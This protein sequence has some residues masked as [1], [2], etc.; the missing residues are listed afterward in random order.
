MEQHCNQLPDENQ[1]KGQDKE[2][3]NWF[4]VKILVPKWPLHPDRVL[5][6]CQQENQQYKLSICHE[7]VKHGHVSQ[8]TKSLSDLLLFFLISIQR[9]QIFLNQFIPKQGFFFR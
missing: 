2:K 4:K 6:K 8:T 1:G 3:A 7:K 5:L 9:V